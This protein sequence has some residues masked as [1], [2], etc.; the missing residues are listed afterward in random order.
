[1]KRK[2]YGSLN[3]R[4]DENK[5]FCEEIKVGTGMTKYFWSDRHAY[6]VVIVIDQKHVFVREY[7]HKMKGQPMSNEWELISN[8]NNPLIEMKF[9]YGHWYEVNRCFY[10]NAHHK[11]IKLVDNGTCK[12]YQAA[13][14]YVLFANNVH[15]KDEKELQDFRNG[16]EYIKY[17][18]VNVSFGIAEHYYDY[19]F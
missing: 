19:E 7:D 12:T 14:N 10:E 4:V 17:N 9:R 6:E 13:F 18:K 8:E 1:M 11:A 3:N 15:F 2:V 5:M 16:K